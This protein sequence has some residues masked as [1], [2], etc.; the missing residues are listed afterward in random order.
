MLDALTA[1]QLAM[2]MDQLKMQS[3]SQNIS[4]MNTPGFKKQLLETPSFAEILEP[5]MGAM[6]QKIN[7][8]Q[9]KSQGTFT[10]T[11]NSKDIAIGGTGYFQVQSEQGLFYTRRGDFQIN[12]QGELSTATGELVLGK[13][14]A[15]KIDDNEFIIN[16]QGEI[17][18]DHH[19]I[20]ELNL[21]KF[22]DVHALH[23]L[24]NGLYQT[25]TSPTPCDSSTRILQGMLEQSNVKS[26]DEMMDLIKTSRHFE[27]SQRI[28]KTSDDMLST[29]ISQLGEG[30]V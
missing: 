29:A 15:I 20:D 24:G 4:N 23:Y 9:L 13:S 7:P 18:V 11:N 25:E 12:S 21:V 30:N 19:K 3:I 2:N 28:L 17:W 26:V 5:G 8:E 27:A 1:T 22:D 6:I 16:A 14:G 10:Q